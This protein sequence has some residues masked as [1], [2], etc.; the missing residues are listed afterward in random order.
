ML[1]KKNFDY[2]KRGENKWTKQQLLKIVI[3]KKEFAE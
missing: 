3:E 2:R 1:F